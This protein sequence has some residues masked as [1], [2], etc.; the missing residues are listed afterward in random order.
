MMSID[1]NIVNMVNIVVVVVYFHTVYRDH[2][3][4][5]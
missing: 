1:V 3:Y 4:N 2:N 5:K